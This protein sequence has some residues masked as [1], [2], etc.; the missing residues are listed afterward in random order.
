MGH[1]VNLL[2][3][4]PDDWKYTVQ[5]DTT[6]GRT[7]KVTGS[8]SGKI[9]IKSDDPSKVVPD[10]SVIILCLPVHQYRPMLD[11]IAPYVNKNRETFIGTV[12]GQAGFD[13]MVES[14]IIKGQ[15]CTKV[16]TFAIGS[17]PWICRTLKYGEKGI[18]YGAKQQNIVAV[19]PPDKFE[20]LNHILLQDI[21]L[22]PLGLGH[23]DQAC[24]FLDLTLSVDNQI[25]HPARCYGLWKA[26][27]GVW[28]T[29][30]KVPYFYRDFDKA[31]ADILELLD[32][33]YEKIRQ[34]IRQKFPEKD[35]KYMLGYSDLEKLNHKSDHVD[36]LA[37]LKDST[38]LASI[39]TPAV[40]G[41]D[42]R[43]YLDTN[44]RFFKDDIPYGLLIAKSLAEM[45][46]V[47]TD[48]IDEVI[49]WAQ[50]LRG[51][52]F[53][54]DGKINM[55]FCLSDKYLCGIPAVYGYTTVEDL[56]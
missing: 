2:T 44:F 35:F 23:F 9:N 39:K 10:A 15:G 46:H 40:Q 3:R 29:A 31:S 8:H 18:N 45:L 4:R 25:I 50:G 14:S 1:T 38:Q 30:S 24:S 19:S 36:I 20:K 32:A 48:F 28:E 54:V 17:I 33:D 5:C 7:G 49:G 13:W 22:R 53:I 27:G 6:D 55:D 11:Q 12:F 21:S 51:E 41:E 47:E 37:S 56:V 43:Y 34:A 42:G 52:K 16:V 26:S